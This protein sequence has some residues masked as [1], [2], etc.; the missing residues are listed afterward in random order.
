MFLPSGVVLP[1][2]NISGPPEVHG[3]IIFPRPLKPEDIEGSFSQVWEFG[4]SEV[5][6]S[7]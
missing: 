3:D 5:A 2:S 7:S 4:L 6:F 1:R